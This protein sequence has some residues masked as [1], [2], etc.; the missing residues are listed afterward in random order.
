MIGE[1]ACSSSLETVSHFYSRPFQ[2]IHGGRFAQVCV[3][4]ITDPEVKQLASQGLVGN[5]D[6][7]SDNTDIEGL[8]RAKLRHLY[9]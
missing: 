4:Q 1:R 6:Q 3:E 9:E 8:E 7:W 2:V 5:V